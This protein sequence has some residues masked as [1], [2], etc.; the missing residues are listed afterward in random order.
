LV[1]DCTGLMDHVVHH[2]PRN[3]G[4]GEKSGILIVNKI[5]V[6]NAFGLERRLQRWGTVMLF[7]SF[8]YQM[9][10]K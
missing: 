2:L 4:L 3:V 9:K 6:I 7:S 1:I 8:Y 5:D 10:T